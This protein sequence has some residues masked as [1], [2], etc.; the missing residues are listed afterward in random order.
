MLSPR[1]PTRAR[2][3]GEN[4]TGLKLD[5]SGG[6]QE[7]GGLQGCT[8]SFPKNLQ[9]GTGHLAEPLPY[10]VLALEFELLIDLLGHCKSRL[11]KTP[12]VAP[13]YLVISHR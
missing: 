7:F 6:C 11:K 9:D 13:F 2:N 12:S 1:T 8:S 4:P 5:V 10:H 3:Y